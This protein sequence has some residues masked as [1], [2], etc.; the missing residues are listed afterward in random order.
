M[1]GYSQGDYDTAADLMATVQG[2]L[3][4]GY[5]TKPSPS[6]A[7]AKPQRCLQCITDPGASCTAHRHSLPG[8]VPGL[9]ETP[10][11]VLVLR[12]GWQELTSGFSDQMTGFSCCMARKPARQLGGGDSWSA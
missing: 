11:T 5:G 10:S 8:A 3:D 4:Q 12:D 9:D 2:N 1:S 7:P 6:K